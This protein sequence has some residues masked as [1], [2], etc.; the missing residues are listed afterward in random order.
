MSSV[1]RSTTTG[2]KIIETLS[3]SKEYFENNQSGPLP[4]LCKTSKV[5]RLLFLTGSL[6]SGTAIIVLFRGEWKEKKNPPI[7]RHN[8]LLSTK[9]GSILR[10]VKNDVN[11]AAKFPDN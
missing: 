10:H 5:D 1:K 11:R 8:Q 6:Q 2:D 4:V 7:I 3:S 9:F